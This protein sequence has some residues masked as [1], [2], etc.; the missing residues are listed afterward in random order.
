M[1][2]SVPFFFLH[3]THRWT[4]VVPVD[5]NGNQIGAPSTITSY[6]G[7][8]DFDSGLMHDDDGTGYGGKWCSLLLYHKNIFYIYTVNINLLH[9]DIYELF[10]SF[11]DYSFF[12]LRNTRQPAV[13]E[14]RLKEMTMRQRSLLLAL[15][16]EQMLVEHQQHRRSRQHC[17]WSSKQ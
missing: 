2:Y 15:A 17:P 7:H 10:F 4:A 16:V 11:M 9:I 12:F 1:D 13:K 5:M 3:K 14:R 8:D 6:S